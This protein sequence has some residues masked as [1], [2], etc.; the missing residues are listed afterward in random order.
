MNAN[1]R[2][3]YFLCADETRY[4]VNTFAFIC[5]FSVRLRTIDLFF[6]TQRPHSG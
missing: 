6:L 4:Q 3:C 2:K 5:A 1:K